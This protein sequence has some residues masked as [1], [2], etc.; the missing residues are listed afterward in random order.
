MD[1]IQYGDVLR[2]KGQMF[3]HWGGGAFAVVFRCRESSGCQVALRCLLCHPSSDAGERAIALAAFRQ[4]HLREVP[5]L[6]RS[7]YIPDAIKVQ[8]EWYPVFIMEWVEGRT[9]GSHVA[10]LAKQRDQQALW[11]LAA[12]WQELVTGLEDLQ[13]AHGDLNHGNVMIT[14]HGE[15]RLVDYDTIFVPDL[16]HRKATAI[17]TPGYVHPSHFLAGIRPYDAHMDTFGAMVI[18]LSLEALAHDPSLYGRFSQDNLLLSNQDL[19]EP[20]SSVA[21]NR[22]KSIHEGDI[23]ALVQQL[24]GACR[25]KQEPALDFPRTVPLGAA[26]PPRRPFIPAAPEYEPGAVISRTPSGGSAAADY[27]PGSAIQKKSGG[28]SNV[29]GSPEEYAPGGAIPRS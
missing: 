11:A 4:A 6:V 20:D 10:E 26:I 8:G 23:P 13:I 25:Q 9:L 12:R 17:G 2:P 22:L 5:F 18:L 24:Q 27:Q 29:P 21:F 28:D 16:V 19:E 15:L 14:D 1:D 7:Q 3:L